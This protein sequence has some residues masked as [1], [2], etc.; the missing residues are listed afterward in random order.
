MNDAVKSLKQ[1]MRGRPW[2]VGELWEAGELGCLG[3]GCARV[4]T[5]QLSPVWYRGGSLVKGSK[6]EPSWQKEQRGQRGTSLLCR[7]QQRRVL[8]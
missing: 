3:E 2:K 1:N 5:R 7:E 6:E 8:I 4:G